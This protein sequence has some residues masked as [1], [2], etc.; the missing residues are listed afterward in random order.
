MSGS[1]RPCGVTAKVKVGYLV[2]G[3]IT[4]A[5]SIKDMGQDPC[6]T[7]AMTSAALPPRTDMQVAVDQAGNDPAVQP[8]DDPGTG[9]SSVITSWCHL[10][11]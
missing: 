10:C 1:G 9:P 8:V 6:S 4:V 7:M 5:D 11:G 2:A 3:M